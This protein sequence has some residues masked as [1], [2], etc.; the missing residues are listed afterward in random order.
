MRF[1]RCTLTAIVAAATVP[2]I[3][4]TPA[5]AAAHNGLPNGTL[6][7][8][9]LVIG[10]DGARFDKLGDAV[11]PNLD[12][13]RSA[14]MTAPSNLQGL[15][16]ADTLSWAGWS[17]IGH[18][19]WPDKHK[20]MGQSWDTNQFSTYPDYLTRL[21]SQKPEAS[22][23]VVGTWGD[24]TTQVFGSAVDLRVDKG[25][26]A[27]TAATAA[28]YLTNGNPD[29]T[30]VQLDEVDGAG[31]SYGG[32]SQKYLDALEDVDTHIGTLLNAV[33]ARP[34][35]ANEDWLIMFTTDHGHR[36]VPDR[37]GVDSPWPPTDY[38]GHGYN[39]PV[40][41]QT[42]VIAKGTGLTGGSTRHD[43]RITDIA[44]TV[45]KHAGVTIN[46]AWN[47]DG[48]P[49][50]NI[51][52]DAFDSLRP[53]L[54]S[55]VDEGIPSSVKGW[56]TTAPSGWSIDN[57][58]MP[59]G[60][61]TEWRGWSF[62]TDEFWTNAQLYQGRE[63]NVRARNVF[64][65]A[66]SDEWDDK[67]HSSGQ[68]NSTLKSPAFPVSGSTAILS[69]ASHYAIDGPQTGKVYVSYNDNTPVLVKDYTQDTNA[70]E[71][72]PLALPAG[73]TNVKVEFRY[74]GTNSAFW[75]VDQVQ[76][77]T[78]HKSLVIGIDGAAYSALAGADMPNL[79][80]IQAGGLTSQANLYAQPMADT[81]SGPGWSTIGHG[82]WPDKHM[83]TSNTAFGQKN[84]AQ[85]PDYLTR[86]E[87]NNPNVST[88]VLG[89]WAPLFDENIFGAESVVDLRVG[90]GDDETADN[91]AGYLQHGNPDSAF[92]HFN[93]LDE[94]GH[95]GHGPGTPEYEAALEHIDSLIGQMMDAVE[96]RDTYGVE[97]W[98]I[99]A[100]SDHGHVLQ[101]GG[102][103]GNSPGE[104][105][106]FVIAKGGGLPA[107]TVRHDIKHVD[108]AP[109]VL[110]HM[111]VTIN[112][113]WNLDGK[114]ISDIIAPSNADPFDSLRPSLNSAVD[115]GIPSSVKGW[116]TTAPSGW[117]ID[118]SAMPTGGATEWRGWS[119][120][121]DEFWTN[122]QLSQGRETNVRARNVFAVADSDEWDDKSH[123][124]GQFN[125]TLKSPAFPVSGSTAILSFASHYAIDGPQ[126]GKVYVSYNGNTPVLVKNYTQDTNAVE[127]IPLAL[128]AGTTN[129]KVEFRYTGTNSAF[130]TVD[131]VQ[132]ATP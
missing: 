3:A 80:S 65:V 104:R 74:T 110:R 34:S 29:S 98:L 30:F 119:F 4:S 50:S 6:T 62:A 99:I 126:T 49:I 90:D 17:T 92:V 86:L 43:V 36:D 60:G 129:V 114:P 46:S 27:A 13:F 51:T 7:K 56:T 45:L 22:T 131:Q 95:E 19:V 11:M 100:T 5:S 91:A 2:M 71:K 63:T 88:L 83:V 87:S 81:S 94:V 73:T 15:P 96:A 117:S 127:K 42:F 77:A 16:M 54:N 97:D 53:S 82:V 115:E 132:I 101:T 85:Y 103:G 89:N 67:S 31:H 48:K 10:I 38:Q 109:T 72:I 107:N 9:T 102:H 121:T 76:I 55:A 41:R 24:I 1:L 26:D 78:T 33:T 40:E 125:S 28:D 108:I 93:E 61:A 14:G 12:A 21:E 105:D 116:T 128:P 35:Y 112:S 106:S 18:G 47:L 39:S 124:S 123:G 66:D 20:V 84:Y 58:A 69:F 57:S 113:A 75:T 68:F 118:N 64:A 111:G 120:A 8:K 59:T 52:P 44:A 37:L 70:V 25:D 130:W 79:D 23:L 122:A 32:A